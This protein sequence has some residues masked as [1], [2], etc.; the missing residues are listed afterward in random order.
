V[1]GNGFGDTARGDDEE[2]GRVADGNTVIADAQGFCTGGA[3]QVEGDLHLS[4]APEIALPANDR[5]TFQQVAGTIRG[6][7]VANIVVSGKYQDSGRAQHLDR[8]H[9]QPAGAMSDQRDTGFRHH[10]RRR[11][12][13][14]G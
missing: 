2:I 7:G 12:R 9:R 8:R 14:R 6:P 11:G 4:V 1:S 13:S 10:R 5:S 3:D